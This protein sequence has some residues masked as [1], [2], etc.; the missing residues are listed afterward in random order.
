MYVC[1]VIFYHVEIEKN[2][3][4]D[5]AEREAT[6]ETVIDENAEEEQDTQLQHIVM[7]VITDRDGQQVTEVMADDAQVAT[8]PM[9]S[10]AQVVTETVNNGA[11]EV[12]EEDQ[13]V[14]EILD[15]EKSLQLFAALLLEQLSQ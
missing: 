7:D 1:T 10:G 15:A 14:V 6:M 3:T 11:Q 13:P 8:E 5:V 4:E 2:K 12:T 9:D